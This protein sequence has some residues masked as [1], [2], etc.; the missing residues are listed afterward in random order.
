MNEN[1]K[2]LAYFAYVKCGDN[3]WVSNIRFN[4][5]Y[6]INLRSGKTLFHG[7]FERHPYDKIVIH[8]YAGK[9]QNKLF[10]LPQ[11]GDSID[12]FDLDTEVIDSYPIDLWFGASVGVVAGRVVLDDVV[13]MLPKSTELVMTTFSLKS[14]SLKAFGEKAMKNIG[15]GAVPEYNTLAINTTYARGKIWFAVFNTN[16]IASIDLYTE[17]ERIYEISNAKE[18][19]TIKYDGIDFW[20]GEGINVIRWTPDTGTIER[21]ENVFLNSQ[22]DDNLISEFVFYGDYVFAIPQ[23][24]GAIVRINKKTKEVYRYM[25]EIENYKIIHKWRDLRNAFVYNDFLIINPVGRNYEISINLQ[26]NN[27]NAREYIAKKNTIYQ[28]QGVF[29]EREYRKL[30]SFIDMIQK[31]V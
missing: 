17:K 19:Q 9:Y 25:L 18:L 29:Y 30:D 28:Y 13:Y 6:S 20:I 14:R 2:K 8:S 7:R 27:I 24:L 3:L 21:F 1:L 23:W 12:L 5:I 26:T 15:R 10:F 22:R 31:N 4:G 16:M 11:N